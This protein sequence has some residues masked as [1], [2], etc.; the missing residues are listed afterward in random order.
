MAGVGISG[1]ELSNS[2]KKD[3]REAESVQLGNEQMDTIKRTVEL[4]RCIVKWT[5]DLWIGT[6]YGHKFI[7]G[8]GRGG[9][10]GSV[11]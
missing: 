9:I 6:L 2:L 3:H 5:L 8:F 1:E 10:S 11:D 7:S 4:F